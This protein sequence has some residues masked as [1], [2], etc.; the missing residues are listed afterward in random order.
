MKRILTLFVIAFI[1][2]VT[3]QYYIEAA[4]T[5]RVIVE[6]GNHE[7]ESVSKEQLQQVRKGI[8]LDETSEE[9]SDQSLNVL[10]PDYIRE[11]TGTV[12]NTWGLNRIGVSGLKKQSASGNQVVVAV[13]DTGVDYNHSFLKNRIVEG[14]DVVGNDPD[15]MDVHFHGTH[16]AGIIVNSSPSNVRIMPI[17][18]LNEEGK[19]YDFQIAQGV[20]YAVDHGAHVINM[21][22]SGKGYS[23]YLA[24]AIEYA[25]ERNVSVVVAAGNETADTALYYP[26]AEQKAIV[27]SATDQN[28]QLAKF[29]NTGSS[30]DLS[31]PGVEIMSTVPGEKAAILSGTSMSAP[32]VSSVVAMLKAEDSNRTVQDIEQLLK[33]NVDDRGQTGWDQ[34]FGQGIINFTSYQGVPTTTQLPVKEKPVVQPSNPEFPPI[35][36]LV[37]DSEILIKFNRTIFQKDVVEIKLEKEGQTIPITRVLSERKRELKVYPTNGFEE[38]GDY[39]LTIQLEKQ[40]IAIKL[41]G[42]ESRGQ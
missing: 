27:V 14:Y 19:G 20:Y 5:D 29:S 22:L 13:L 6:I 32:Y 2:M 17:R 21:S 9:L 35:T 38:T 41:Y 15:P 11:I 7:V 37:K 10:Q 26:A 4:E 42:K 1:C 24:A 25:L 34:Q 31:A 30:I 33:A 36:D 12:I 39:L 23:S 16:V 18:V 40:K 3:D 8:T 28:D